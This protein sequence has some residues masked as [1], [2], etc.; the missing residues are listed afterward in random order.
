METNCP[1]VWFIF[2]VLKLYGLFD[3]TRFFQNAKELCA[4]QVKY[5]RE[6][7]FRFYLERCLKFC[8]KI[9]ITRRR[10][11]RRLDRILNDRVHDYFHLS[12]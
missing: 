8:F 5:T 4:K 7:S 6:N 1:R 3:F 11:D 12:L 9:T 10:D 2:L